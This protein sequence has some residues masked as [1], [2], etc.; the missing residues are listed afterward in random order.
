MFYLCICL[1]LNSLATPRGIWDFSSQTEDRTH[2]PC[3]GN[4][5]A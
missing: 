2:A 4:A 1:F 5:E 3:I